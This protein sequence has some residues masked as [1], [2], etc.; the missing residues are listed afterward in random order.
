[1]PL[2]REHTKSIP[3]AK[4]CIYYIQYILYILNTV[5][6]I[7]CMLHTYSQSKVILPVRDRT[8]WKGFNSITKINNPFNYFFFFFFSKINNPFTYFWCF[9]YF[10]FYFNLIIKTTFL[11]TEWVTPSPVKGRNGWHF[12]L[13]RSQTALELAVMTRTFASEC[14]RHDRYMITSALSQFLQLKWVIRNLQI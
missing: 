1:M 4:Y 6:P 11:I 8:L 3:Y 12:S 13:T 2:V 5:N 14:S 10:T 9:L 7:C